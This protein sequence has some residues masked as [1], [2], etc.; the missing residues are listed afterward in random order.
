[1]KEWISQKVLPEGVSEGHNCVGHELQLVLE[2][3]VAALQTLLGRAQIL[4]LAVVGRQR[5]VW[6]PALEVVFPKF[7]KQEKIF[8]G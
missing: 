5:G 3:H 6:V 8:V 7:C 4:V 1:M 2:G